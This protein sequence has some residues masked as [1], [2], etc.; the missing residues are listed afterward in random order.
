MA[1]GGW[2]QGNI[3]PAADFAFDGT[4]V[5]L[6]YPQ[7]GELSRERLRDFIVERAPESR[8]F[9]ARE[10]HDDGNP[11]LHAYIHFGRRRRFH[12]G[13][14]F[15]VDGHHPNIQKPRSARD[16]VTYCGKEDATPLANFELAEI[17]RGER[18][19]WDEVV[20]GAESRDEFLAL[21]RE[22]FPRDYVLSLERIL[23]F[24]EWRFGRGEV[25]YVGRHRSEFVELPSL[26]DWV[27]CNLVEV[28]GPGGPQSPPYQT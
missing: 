25:Q 14:C 5:F 4:H 26:R 22:R 27:S 28:S 9:I 24:C 2:Q 18:G 17:G 16:V 6:T 12:G 7:C 21:V 20:S 23:F 1:G 13:H 19:G 3:M 15:D 11:H 8:Y 10:L